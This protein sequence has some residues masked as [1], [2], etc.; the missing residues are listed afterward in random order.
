MSDSSSFSERFTNLIN[1]S[2]SKLMEAYY[3]NTRVAK[4]LGDMASS[5]KLKEA[6]E[7][8]GGVNKIKEA[9]EKY[10]P[11][12]LNNAIKVAGG[13]DNFN[14]ALDLLETDKHNKPS[15]KI[16]FNDRWEQ[17]QSFRKNPKAMKKKS[18]DW[19]LNKL[20]SRTLVAFHKRAE[21]SGDLELK[22]KINHLIT[23]RKKDV[24]E[25]INQRVQ[26]NFRLS[27]EETKK[28]DEI[29]RWLEGKK[30]IPMLNQ[31]INVEKLDSPTSLARELLNISIEYLYLASLNS[32]QIN[33]LAEMIVPLKIGAFDQ[34]CEDEWDLMR[35]YPNNFYEDADG[36]P[37]YAEQH[38]KDFYLDKK[39]SI[40]KTAS[41]LFNV[42]EK[43]IEKE[44]WEIAD[45]KADKII[46]DLNDGQEPLN[47]TSKLRA[48]IL[49]DFID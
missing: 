24:Q 40:V 2:V 23:E 11:K 31:E 15:S 39:K 3:E 1:P 26:V 17:V 37:I 8:S 45:Q 22:N 32:R 35:E 44:F 16:D 49:K 4:A 43:L 13:E 30:N 12:E 36:A 38:Q 7:L 9:L 28:I 33:A 5:R 10:G 19:Y 42:Q 6:I 41:L 48:N 18:L 25:T 34:E 47:E 27:E 20:N 46:K 21:R 29:Q 14:D